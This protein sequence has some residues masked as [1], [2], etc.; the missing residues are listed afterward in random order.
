VTGAAEE[1]E[2]PDQARPTIPVRTAAWL[3]LRIVGSIAALVIAYYLLPLDNASAAVVG[4]ILALG[5]ATFVAWMAIQVRSIVRSP[6]PGLRG[7]EALATGIPFFLLLFASAYVAMSDLWPESFTAIL[8]HSDG[9]YFTVTVFST[10]GFGDIVA[11]SETARLVVTGQMLADLV[12]L[13]VAIKVVVGAV[14]RGVRRRA[15]AGPRA[16]GG[17]TRR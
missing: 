13:G 5:L 7:L 3:I 17:A 6:Y 14:R 2:I 8:S 16:D 4:T 1:P 11:K 15:P 10:V 9:L 12:V